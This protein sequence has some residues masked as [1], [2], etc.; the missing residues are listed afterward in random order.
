[1]PVLIFVEDE[2][3][4]PYEILARKALGLPIERYNRKE[5][6]VSL[7]KLSDFTSSDRL[8][9]LVSGAYEAG[10]DCVLFILDHEDSTNSPDRQ[11]KLVDFRNAFDDLCRHLRGLPA[12]NQLRTVNVIRIVALNCLESWL[13]ADPQAIVDAVRGNQGV[14]YNPPTRNTESLTPYEAADQI[15]NHIRQVGRLTEKRDLLR[16]Q[17]SNIKRRGKVIA[18]R[19]DIRRSRNYNRS[20]AY[21]IEMVSCE[22]SGCNSP[23]PEHN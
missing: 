21:F 12:T 4:E 10:Y 18:A 19:L 17:A 14:R 6:K 15:A 3:N 2:L 22:I 7:A 1:M 9:N 13:A 11:Q 16:A 8:L 23:C 20:L 5:V